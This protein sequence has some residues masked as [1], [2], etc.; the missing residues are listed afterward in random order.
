MKPCKIGACGGPHSQY[1]II[2]ISVIALESKV[3]ICFPG[4]SG[5]ILLF[6]GGVINHWWANG[7]GSKITIAG[8]SE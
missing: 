5:I 1:N 8:K 3:G 7:A 6:K 4:A 2:V